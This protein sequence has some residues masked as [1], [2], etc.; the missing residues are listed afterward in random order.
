MLF[1]AFE[2]I[3]ARNYTIRDIRELAKD[4]DVYTMYNAHRQMKAT[5][6]SMKRP[7]LIPEW[8]DCWRIHPLSKRVNDDKDDIEVGKFLLSLSGTAA[9]LIFR[10]KV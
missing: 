8:G 1:E 2:Q 6:E 5:F 10:M 4:P 9:F 3:D 7:D